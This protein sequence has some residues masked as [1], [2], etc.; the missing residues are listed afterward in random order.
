MYLRPRTH[1]LDQADLEFV[2]LLPLT[3]NAAIG[4]HHQL[5][6]IFSLSLNRKHGKEW[7]STRWDG[8]EV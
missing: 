2:I 8:R 1:F 3:L 7:F 5:G 4:M 6:A